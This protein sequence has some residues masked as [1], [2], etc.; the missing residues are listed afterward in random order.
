MRISAGLP[1]GVTALLF[2]PARARRRLEARLV[3][4]LERQGF[5][6]A[7]LPIL[8]YHEPYSSLL[9]P[10]SRDELYRFV[11]RDGELLQLRND[12]TPMLARL[13]APRLRSG[14]G[15]VGLG[16][17]APGLA[18]EQPLRLFYR[19]DVVRYQEARPGRLRETYQLGAEL[20]GP[21]FGGNPNED[22]A[23]Q[24]AAADALR[25]R[26]D[27][28]ILC[29]C[30][31]LLIEGGVG[32]GQVVL[33]GAG[34][35]DELLKRRPGGLKPETLAA[36]LVRRDREVA[37][38]GGALLLQVLEEGVPSDGA[39][40]GEAAARR[41][42]ALFELAERLERSYGG[43]GLQTRVDL[44]EYATSTLSPELLMPDSTWAYYDG[45]VFRVYLRGNA[46]PV[47]QGGRYDRLFRTLGAPVSAV[48]F[49]LG[50]DRL[51]QHRAEI[52]AGEEGG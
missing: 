12:F 27:E 26:C 23:N 3:E 5:D 2:E 42:A 15:G 1:T 37:R 45:L 32:E 46:L 44:A 9:S 33:G 7:I 14:L 6:E 38:R 21:G 10:G 41:V 16:G 4:R 18:G 19:G 24:D 20:L 40:L 43:S 49:S 34:I 13:I 17:V 22:S 47:A 11:D 51:L 50:L 35:L 25:R 8:D 30:L 31:E 39:A 29:L 28:E 36:A 48:G 52:A